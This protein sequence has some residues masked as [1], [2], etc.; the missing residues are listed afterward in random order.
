MSL[1]VRNVAPKSS[2]DAEEITD[3]MVPDRSQPYDY[4]TDR[5]QRD[6]R[7]SRIRKNN[8][9]QGEIHSCCEDNLWRTASTYESIIKLDLVVYSWSI[10][11]KTGPCAQ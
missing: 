5:G 1:T 10:K 3:E 8:G 4:E 11:N 7:R 6:K 2:F 9:H